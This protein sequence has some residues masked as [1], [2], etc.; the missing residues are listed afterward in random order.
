MSQNRYSGTLY[1]LI[2]PIRLN[3]LNTVLLRTSPTETQ[4]FFCISFA[5][6]SNLTANETTL[7][8]KYD[9][10]ISHC[11]FSKRKKIRG[12]SG[13]A[14]ACDTIPVTHLTNTEVH[15]RTYGYRLPQ[16]FVVLMRHSAEERQ[17][18]RAKAA[19]RRFAYSLNPRSTVNGRSVCSRLKIL[20][21]TAT[22]SSKGS[23]DVPIA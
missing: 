7:L 18:P 20:R 10:F 15:P 1:F 14:H 12:V 23:L 21:R 6:L 3:F 19:V 16:T 22:N 11:L 2:F 4:S 8:Y 9:T 13:S 5:S 17:R